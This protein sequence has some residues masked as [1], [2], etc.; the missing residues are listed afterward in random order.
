M[1]ESKALTKK[2]TVASE[3]SDYMAL[4]KLFYLLIYMTY[5]M[6]NVAVSMFFS[7]HYVTNDTRAR[8][9]VNWITAQIQDNAL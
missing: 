8:E 2:V 1:S 4:Y 3:S 9:S 6:K 7:I 5:T